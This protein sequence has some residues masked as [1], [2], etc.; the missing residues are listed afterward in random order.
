MQADPIP[1]NLK[2]MLL[3][4]LLYNDTLEL[5]AQPIVNLR[6]GKVE[7]VEVLSRA[8]GGVLLPDEM[9][10]LARQ[11]G[12]LEQLTLL[13]CRKLMEKIE[14]LKPMS[15]KG[16][17]LNI[18]ADVSRHT[19]EKAAH[20][21]SG[22]QGTQIVLEVT[23]HVPGGFAWR[24]FADAK[25]YFIAMDDFGKGNSNMV[26]LIEM[27]PHFIKVCMEIVGDLHKSGTKAIIIENFKKIGESMNS[28]VIAEGVENQ[29]DMQKL[30]ELGIEYGQGFHFSRPYLINE[31]PAEE[32]QA[33]F[34]HKL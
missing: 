2:P 5:A 10:R 15:P 4:N 9:Y 20:I 26:E 14:F 33:G 32:W 30:R 24:K 13:S 6:T 1:N 16:V 28:Y 18:E 25:G 31:L 8:P 19:L 27:K 17:F 3:F 29:E 34:G 11:Y 21:L 23:E 12:V 7:A 22:A